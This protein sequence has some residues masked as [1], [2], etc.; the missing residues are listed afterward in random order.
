MLTDK[1]QFVPMDSN[2]ELGDLVVRY[3][4]EIKLTIVN[5]QISELE[6]RLKAAH[7]NN[8]VDLQ[9]QLLAHQP[10]LLA[11]RNELCKILG[12]RVINI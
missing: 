6:Q 11:L 5:M 4:Y 10:E 7:V 9:L 12:N 2:S 8:D 3:L 1:Y